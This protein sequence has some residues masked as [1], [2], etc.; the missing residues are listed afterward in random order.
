M[1]IVNY[2]SIL[3]IL[4]LFA[5]C[6][7]DLRGGIPSIDLGGDI[8]TPQIDKVVENV[9]PNKDSDKIK[10]DKPDEKPKDE[11]PVDEKPTEEKPVDETINYISMNEV[12]QHKQFNDC[13]IVIDDKVYDAKILIT[14]H[15]SGRVL[16]NY[17]G[18]DATD[19]LRNQLFKGDINFIE[20]S[21]KYLEQ[22][23]LGDLK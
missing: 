18:K 5:G 23:Y 1:K 22:S 13:W 3:F 8:L 12:Q 20:N 6:T 4:V 9:T 11:K 10:D 2:F 21:R 16:I 15:P 19:F 17:C 14:T 7:I